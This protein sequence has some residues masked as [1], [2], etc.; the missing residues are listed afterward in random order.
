ME[1]PHLHEDSAAQQRTSPVAGIA[2][3]PLSDPRQHGITALALKTGL[4]AAGSLVALGDRIELWPIEKLRPYERSPRTHSE[5]QVDQIAASMVEFG[6]TN[7]ILINEQGGILAGHGRLLA[8]RKLGLAEVPVI[9]FEHLSE[10][11]KR[12]YVLADN[13][14]ALQ[15]GWDDA[16]LAE[17][18]AW[19]WDERFDLDLIGLD[20]TELE[21]LLAIADGEAGSDEGEDEVPEPPEEP[22]SKPCDLWVLGNHRLL[23][24]DATVLT[25]IERLLGGQ[26][27]DMCF[28]DSPY[29]VDYANSPKDKLR[30]K[31][32]PNLNDNLGSGFEAFLCDG[33]GDLLDGGTLGALEH[34]DHLSLLGARAR[35][36]LGGRLAGRRLGLAGGRRG[37]GVGFGGLRRTLARGTGL[38]R[39]RGC[40]G[41]RGA[42]RRLVVPGLDADRG[43]ALAG[44]D[45]SLRPAVGVEDQAA[46]AEAVHHLG[47]RERIIAEHE[48]R[49]AEI[50]ALRAKDG[51]NAEQ[52]DRLIE[53]SAA[54][55]EAQLSQVRAKEAGAADKV[56]AANNRVVEGLNAERAALTRTERERFVA[57][58]MSRLS[59][60]ATAQQR[61][62]VEELPGALYDEQQALQA[63][64]RLMGEGRSVTDRTRTAPEQYG[65][66]VAKLNELLAA[67]AIDEQTYTRA[68][69]GERPGAP[70][71]PGVHRWRDPFPQ[72]LRR[73]E[74]GRRQWG[75]T[76]LRAGL[77]GRR[78]CP[79]RLRHDRQAG[80][81]GLGGQ[82]AR[83]HRPHGGAP[84][85]H[86][87]A[88]R[89]AAGWARRWRV[90]TVPR[91][92]R[93]GRAAAGGALR[94]PRR[95]RARAPLPR[96]RLRGLGPP[97]RQ[98]ADHRPPR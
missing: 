72:G 9:R 26:L 61:R 57:Q 56:R 77:L 63:R 64:Q 76:S 68:V 30:G 80:D 50:E 10:P 8:A 96:W 18:V 87:T 65:A 16:L 53:D 7:P 90:R 71:E 98:G 83:R 20:A 32:R 23:C 12:A 48:R 4:N 60:E 6:W 5:A 33:R 58:A 82:R 54:V 22:L 36:G 66:E 70:L 42:R 79:D 95:L 43:H 88:R 97:P 38:G 40:V 17:E 59:A 37:R 13:Q 78:G 25:D 2:A 3:R 46:V 34:V 35:R 67:G 55:R 1:F 81:Q 86:G 73:R 41:L 74:P 29:N 21:R 69:E 47:E 31:H 89:A 11:Q 49:L 39:R 45:H 15:A 44:D 27:A 51:S 19:L 85:D 75:R 93:R 92:R 28:T 94:R 62:E 84:D 91:G 52:I 14:I 24:G